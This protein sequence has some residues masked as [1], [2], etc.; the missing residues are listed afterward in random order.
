[1]DKAIRLFKNPNILKLLPHSR[2]LEEVGA[3]ESAL[4]HL[5]NPEKKPRGKAPFFSKPQESPETVSRRALLREL[6][7]TLAALRYA[8]NCFEHASDPEIVE[9]CVY[10]IKSAEARYSYL[11]R[12]AKETGVCRDTL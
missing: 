9:A 4:R 3:R 1:M 5:L 7:D 12:R 10:E 6:D 8:R 11:L 2:A